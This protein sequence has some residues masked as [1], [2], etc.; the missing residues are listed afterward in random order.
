MQLEDLRTSIDKID[1]QIVELYAQRMNFAK[2][3]ATVKK[4][5]GVAISNSLREK[6]S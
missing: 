6:Y 2:Q 5:D 3:I 1:D 4:T